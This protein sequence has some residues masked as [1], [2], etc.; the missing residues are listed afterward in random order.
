MRSRATT[1]PVV[2]GASCCPLTVPARASI[3]TQTST[4]RHPTEADRRTDGQ[5]DSN[6]KRWALA[7]DLSSAELGFGSLRELTLRRSAC[8]PVRPSVFGR[9]PCHDNTAQPLGGRIVGISKR[10]GVSI[11]FEKN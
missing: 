11:G 3:A 10:A 6:V 2:G 4:P 5:P 9:L 8:P 1:P 7:N